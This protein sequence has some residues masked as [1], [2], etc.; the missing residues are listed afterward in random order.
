MIVTIW[1][2]KKGDDKPTPRKYVCESV[3]IEINP[4]DLPQGDLYMIEE[5]STGELEICGEISPTI[6]IV[7]N[8]LRMR[9]L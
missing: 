8:G 6:E 5:T 3:D 4:D 9:Q 1:S 2:I 7:R